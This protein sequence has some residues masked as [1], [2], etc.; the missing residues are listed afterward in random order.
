MN[1][2]IEK[3]V[4]AVAECRRMKPGIWDLDPNAFVV[5]CGPSGAATDEDLA[6]AVLQAIREPGDD[7]ISAAKDADPDLFDG[8]ARVVYQAMID[9]ALAPAASEG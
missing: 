8:E 9:A 6:R 4:A 7:M 5:T 3:A 2:M 1:E